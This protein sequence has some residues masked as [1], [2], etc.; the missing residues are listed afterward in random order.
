[1]EN[2][3]LPENSCCSYEGSQQESFWFIIPKEPIEF[4]LGQGQVN[5]RDQLLKVE[6]CHQASDLRYGPGGVIPPNATL[7]LMS[8]NGR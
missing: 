7:I 6:T 4:K 3:Q 2:K 1:M 8:G 5:R